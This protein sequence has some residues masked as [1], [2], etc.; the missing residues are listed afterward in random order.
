MFIKYLL[1]MYQAGA[2]F[3]EQDWLH[4]FS[5]VVYSLMRKTDSRQFIR[6]DVLGKR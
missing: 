6:T 3:C 2:R 1:Y 4:C 5:P